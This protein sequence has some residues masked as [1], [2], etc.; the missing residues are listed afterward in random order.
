MYITLEFLYQNPPLL[1]LLH[2]IFSGCSAASCP[3]AHVKTC[4]GFGPYTPPGTLKP[5][6]FWMVFWVG[7]RNQTLGNGNNRFGGEWRWCTRILGLP[8]RPFGAQKTLKGPRWFRHFRGQ[9]AIL[10][11][12]KCSLT[13]LGVI[14]RFIAST[15]PSAP[16]SGSSCML[17]L[18]LSAKIRN[19]TTLS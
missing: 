6:I 15:F 14:L 17:E 10:H 5:S 16:V 11:S 7:W 4:H 13:F 9:I 12:K 1:R 8:N 3:C 18:I 19:G 2:P